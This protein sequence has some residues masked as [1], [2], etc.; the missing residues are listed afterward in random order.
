MNLL[1]ITPQSLKTLYDKLQARPLGHFLFNL[2][3][4][5]AIPYSGTIN[6]HVIELQPGWAKVRLPDRRRVRNH[7]NSIHAVALTNLGEL[8]SG[9]ALN[10]ALPQNTRGIVT[11]LTTDFF[12]KA[13][14]D[15]IATCRCTLPTIETHTDFT[16]VAEIY[17]A[18]QTCVA[19]TTVHW[20]LSPIIDK[21]TP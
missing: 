3:L 9:L 1:A 17:D 12:K 10:M 18:K 5:I 15:L 4:K 16:V 13:R 19:K 14:G 20:R 6:A 8:T 11:C 21:N 7:L 2:T